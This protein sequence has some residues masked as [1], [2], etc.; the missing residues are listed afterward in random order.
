MNHK[1]MS[2]M[3]IIN[4]HKVYVD[5]HSEVNTELKEE[6]EENDYLTIDEA[7]KLTIEAVKKYT[8]NM[9]YYK[10]HYAATCKMSTI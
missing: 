2:N 9:D 6:V 3:T 8:N 10:N 7:R 5:E 4:G 1:K